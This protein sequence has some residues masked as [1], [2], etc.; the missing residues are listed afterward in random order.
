M[1]KIIAIVSLLFVGGVGAAP[2]VIGGHIE[3]EM[4]RMAELSEHISGPMMS[5]EVVDYTRG[6]L[7]SEAT[8]RISMRQGG[9]TVGLEMKHR[10]QHGPNPSWGLARVETDY[11]LT[12]PMGVAVNKAFGGPAV[13]SVSTVSFGGDWVEQITS[14]A[15]DIPLDGAPDTTL[16]WLGLSGTATVKDDLVHMDIDAPGFTVTSPEVEVRMAGLDMKVDGTV[17][18][19]GSGMIGE[20]TMGMD[21]LTVAENGETVMNLGQVTVSSRTEAGANATLASYSDISVDGL[22]VVDAGQEH[23]FTRMHMATSLTNLN[24]E[25]MDR[26]AQVMA[27]EAQAQAVPAMG[28]ATGQPELMEAVATLL[29]GSPVFE[30]TDLTIETENGN[31]DADMRLTFNGDNFEWP[32]PLP[33][34]IGRLDFA[35]HAETPPA[36]IREV[37]RNYAIYQARAQGATQE[38]AEAAVPTQ[39]IDQQLEALV[40]QG[41]LEK[42]E[43][44]YKLAFTFKDGAVLLNGKPA[45]GMLGSLMG[46][47]M[48]SGA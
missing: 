33:L 15:I 5:V 30:V 40:V 42:T 34:M 8:T 39:M 3:K 45:D 25:A 7:T 14:E 9:E 36:F 44:R 21:E 29:Q 20:S 4:D 12:G 11:S 31:F 48:G 1:K 19:A 38:E 10:I 47:A 46:A 22:K 32:T 37:V 24:A 2:W 16:T 41:I 23:G 13:T 35:L 6:Y 43:T 28:G 26:L 18:E 17:N 27:K